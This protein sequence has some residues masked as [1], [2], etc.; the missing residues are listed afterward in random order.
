MLMCDCSEPPHRQTI[1]LSPLQESLLTIV[2]PHNV[3][4]AATHHIT[5][6]YDELLLTRTLA[7]TALAESS[8]NIVLYN[9]LTRIFS[10]LHRWL[11]LHICQ[12]IIRNFRFRVGFLMS[13]TN[14][15]TVYPVRD[16]I[17]P[18]PTWCMGRLTP[19]FG[20]FP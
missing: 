4:V 16:G 20:R 14:Q 1:P 8:M 6:G 7:L 3:S 2:R 9:V 11:N 13:V 10:A 12:N 5:M 15:K 18:Q 17:G 19:E